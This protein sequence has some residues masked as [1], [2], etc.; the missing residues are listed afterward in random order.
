MKNEID[1]DQALIQWKSVYHISEIIGR[2][3]SATIQH[4]LM[5]LGEFAKLEVAIKEATKLESHLDIIHEA[6]S[7]ARLRRNDYVVNLQGIS[8]CGPRIFLLMEL[9]HFGDLKS[10]LRKN[11]KLYEDRLVN[12]NYEN[13]LLWCTQVI[14]GMLFLAEKK[15]LHVS[16]L[17]SNQFKDRKS[18]WRFYIFVLSFRDSAQLAMTARRTNEPS[19]MPCYIEEARIR[20]FRISNLVESEI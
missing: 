19:R 9:C 6:K 8:Y 18:F 4:G 7:L 12:K 3:N 20:I 5:G 11:Q 2:G 13:H 17:Y 14:A 15:I 1:L 10:Y 16:N